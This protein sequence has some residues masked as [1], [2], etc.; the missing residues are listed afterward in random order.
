MEATPC[1]AIPEKLPSTKTAAFSIYS[2]EM[3]KPA[4]T[5][6]NHPVER[7]L[8][9]LLHFLQFLSDGNVLGTMLFTL[10]AA[11][12]VACTGRI[13]PEG[14]TL[15]IILKG[16]FYVYGYAKGLNLGFKLRWMRKMR[17]ALPSEYCHPKGTAGSAEGTGDTALPGD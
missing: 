15:Q 10:S 1:L 9:H 5:F 8:Q 14:G 2:L 7:C 4:C 12:T 17:K 6:F 11:D 3:Y 16:I 13:L